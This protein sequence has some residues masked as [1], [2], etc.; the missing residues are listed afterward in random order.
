MKNLMQSLGLSMAVFGAPVAAQWLEPVPSDDLAR[1]RAVGIV[2]ANGAQGP[3]SCSGVLVGPN[4]VLTAAH[5]AGGPEGPFDARVFVPGGA[6]GEEPPEYATSRIDL[7]PRYIEAT[8][9]GTA[10]AVDLALLSLAREVPAHVAT[11]LPLVAPDNGAALDGVF[12]IL[13]FDR[14]QPADLKARFDCL[15]VGPDAPDQL[16]LACPVSNGNSGAPV[17]MRTMQGWRIVGVTAARIGRGPSSQSLVAVADAW[18]R[19]RIAAALAR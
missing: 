12:A 15:P 4:L 2:N 6:A 10:F 5:C 11:P 13:G 17:F 8:S 14:M 18:V 16:R 1:W 7:H 19:D 9:D 3:A